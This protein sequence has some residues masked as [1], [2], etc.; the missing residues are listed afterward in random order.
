MATSN[1]YKLDYDS[2]PTAQGGLFS[3]VKMYIYNTDELDL[4]HTIIDVTGSAVPNSIMF[5][6]EKNIFDWIKKTSLELSIVRE[7]ESWL[8]I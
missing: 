7:D 2:F 6:G 5:D 1:V 8:Q 4:Y 3:P